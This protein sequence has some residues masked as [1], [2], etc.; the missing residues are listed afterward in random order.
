VV[1]ALEGFEVVSAPAGRSRLVG[2]V[3]DQAALQ[4][5]LHQLSDLKV[6]IID[7]H[8]VDDP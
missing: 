1:A 3:V 8:R 7:V 4:G 2:D 5:A 6:D